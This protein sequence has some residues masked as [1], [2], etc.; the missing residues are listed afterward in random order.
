[1]LKLFTAHEPNL[2]TDVTLKRNAILSKMSARLLCHQAGLSYTAA[3]AEIE[4]L[5]SDNVHYVQDSTDDSHYS[6]VFSSC[7]GR[8]TH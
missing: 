8:Y 3:K 4:T 6:P 5:L 2:T 1:M 7:M